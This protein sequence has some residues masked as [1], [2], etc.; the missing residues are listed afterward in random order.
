MGAA[1]LAGRGERQTHRGARR[2]LG[3]D[4]GGSRRQGQAK[5]QAKGVEVSQAEV[6]QATRDS[7]R[8]LMLIRAYRVR[9]H[10][11]ANLDPLLFYSPLR[12]TGLR[13]G[14]PV[15][16]CKTRGFL[17]AGRAALLAFEA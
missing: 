8:A 16:S 7:V 12:M 2:Q 4:R 15:G 11:H 6:L 3:L 17:L 13:T 10:L 14:R 1:E 5:S 9:G